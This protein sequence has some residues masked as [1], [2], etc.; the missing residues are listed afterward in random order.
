MDLVVPIAV[1]LV[2]LESD[3]REFPVIDFGSGRVATVVDFSMNL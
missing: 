1:E 3:T 2:A